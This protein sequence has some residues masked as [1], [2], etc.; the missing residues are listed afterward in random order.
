MDKLITIAEF[1][2]TEEANIARSALEAQDIGAVVSEMAA[3]DALSHVGAVARVKLQVHEENAEAANKLLKLTREATFESGWVCHECGEEVD[4]GFEVCW[5]CG[6]V[7]DP[8]NVLP[9]RSKPEADEFPGDADAQRA[10]RCAILSLFLFPFAI[11][12]FI[13]LITTA[14]KEMSQRGITH[15]LIALVLTLVVGLAFAG[16]LYQLM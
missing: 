12:T 4:V 3:A 11:L 1:A 6:A 16:F 5:S 15:Y 9:A 7:F 14:G 8:T 2:S 13:L 10:F